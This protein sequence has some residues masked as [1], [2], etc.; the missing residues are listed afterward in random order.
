MRCGKR[1]LLFAL[2]NGLM[3]PSYLSLLAQYGGSERQGAVQGIANSSGSLASIIGLIVG[4]YLFGLMNS[5]VF[6]LTAFTLGIVLIMSM[7]MKVEK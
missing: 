6:Y 7:I 2:G 4:G 3:W 5:G 1:Q